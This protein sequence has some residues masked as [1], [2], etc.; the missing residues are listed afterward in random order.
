[1]GKR[2]PAPQPTKMKI[3]RGNPGKRPLNKHEPQ[4]PPGTPRCPSWL[5]KVAKAK[6]RELAPK[7]SAA[8]VLTCLDGDALTCYCRIW[9]R[10]KRAEE[11]IETHGT[12]VEI[13]YR[14]GGTKSLRAIPQVAIAHS[15]LQLLNR[16]QQ[17]FGLTPSARAR[18]HVSPAPAGESDFMRLINQN[19]RRSPP[20]LEEHPDPGS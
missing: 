11:Y 1:M 10:W 17:E 19:R 12:V 13:A 7:L 5:G 9:S 2:G 18:L 3:L 4:P 14:Q 6:W 8:G 20:E 15:L 16:Y